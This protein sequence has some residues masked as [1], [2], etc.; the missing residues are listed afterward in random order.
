V[1]KNSR[2]LPTPSKPQLNDIPSFLLSPVDFGNTD[3]GRRYSG[4]TN[5]NSVELRFASPESV[6]ALCTGRIDIWSLALDTL[7]CR[8]AQMDISEATRYANFDN[9]IV[10]QRF[11]ASRTALRNIL[12]IYLNCAPDQ[13]Q[14]RVETDGKPQLR[15]ASLPLFFNLT[16]SENRALLAVRLDHEIGLDIE[17]LRDIPQA[18]R[19]AR[20]IF[21]RNEIE[22]LE[23]SA[24]KEK[25]FLE[26]WTC[27]EARQ[28]CLGR[29]VFGI[30]V[31]EGD[32]TSRTIQVGS[33]VCA[34]V[35]WP[36]QA[37]P[38]ALNFIEQS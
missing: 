22:Q 3:S 14:L 8:T 13:I 17:M 29:G 25:L 12:G 9:A 23:R 35:S 10:R 5:L 24:R 7:P 27:M 38:H 31:N 2:L 6:Q 32:V 30:P 20:R 16:H 28:K 34:A 4:D 19:I 11:C 33:G 26:L 1:Q 21:N 15:A 37:E 36:R 18:K